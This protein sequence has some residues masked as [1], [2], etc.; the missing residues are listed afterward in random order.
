MP[1]EAKPYVERGWYISCPAGRRLRLCPQEEGMARAKELLR[2]EL[3]RISN[4]KRQHAGRLPRDL[5]V[6]DLFALF[7]DSVKV[8]CTEYTY[9]D[10]RLW[11]RRFAEQH[12]RRK[13]RDV[14][15]RDAE[16]FRLSIM[17]ATWL[18]GKKKTPQRYANKTIDHALIALRRAFNWAVA[19]EYLSAPSPFAGI[20]LQPKEYRSRLVSEVE[21]QSLLA[22]CNNPAFRDVLVASRYTDA[23]PAELL[24]LKWSMV[25]WEGKLWLL[26]FHKTSKTSRRPVPRVIGMHPVVEEVLR[27]RREEFPQS[28][29]VFLDSRGNPWKRNALVQAMRRLVEGAGFK[30]D[31]NEESLTLYCNRRTFATEM[32]SEA[33]IPEAVRTMALG[34]TNPQTTQAYYVR[35]QAGQAAEATRKVADRLA[36]QENRPGK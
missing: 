13:A 9:S 36:N 30:P 32:A 20:K 23:R 25:D 12:G 10:Y 26:R 7:L 21:Y 29:Y 18:K 22:S 19:N 1:R 28:E 16:Q 15:K 27:R 33:T 6:V 2:E 11:L 34:H 17:S 31:A 24:R 8:E 35:L 14:G 4:E 5:C 3:V